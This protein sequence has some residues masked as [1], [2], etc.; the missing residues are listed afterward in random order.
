[1]TSF[2]IATFNIAKD[3]KAFPK[4]IYALAKESLLKSF[5]IICLQEDYK[6]IDFYSSK[7]INQKLNFNSISTSIRK[8]M[9]NYKFSSSNITLLSRHKIKLL[10]EIIFDE[11]GLD[12]RACHICKIKCKDC[13]IIVANTHLTHIDSDTRLQQID[14]I[15]EKLEAY[16]DQTI[17]L[18]GD[19]NANPNSQEI[20]RFLEAGFV[21]DNT[22][23]THEDDEIL[24]YI[25]YKSPSSL[26]I[27]SS[28]CLKEYSD[29]YCLGYKV[30]LNASSLKSL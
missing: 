14:T 4:R 24:D 3:E 10:E 29:H 16:K 2:N 19:L 13:K 7:V 22:Q 28:I 15:I 20:Q 21:Y 17:F 11:E 18:C 5:D 26:N 25:L 30:E 8:K 27:E 23:S 1:M 6:S 9:R 12:E